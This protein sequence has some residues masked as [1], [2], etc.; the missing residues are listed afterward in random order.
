[1]LV[2]EQIIRH[3]RG[4]W[5]LSIVSCESGIIDSSNLTSGLLATIELDQD[6]HYNNTVFAPFEH[7]HKVQYQTLVSRGHFQIFRSSDHGSQKRI[8]NRSHRSLKLVDNLG[9]RGMLWKYIYFEA[10]IHFV[11][12]GKLTPLVAQADI[13]DINRFHNFK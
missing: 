11:R 6:I 8:N 12:L 3:V 7:W 13:F 5:W 4:I 1:M 2:L 10:L 9:S